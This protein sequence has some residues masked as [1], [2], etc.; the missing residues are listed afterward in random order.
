M[1]NIKNL[2]FSYKLGK[3]HISQTILSNFSLKV[4]RGEFVALL[5]KSGCGKTT[6]VNL[7]AGYLK[8]DSGIIKIGRKTKSWPDRDRIVIN[9]ENDLFEWMTAFQNIQIVAINKNPDSIREYLRLAGLES[10]SD[11]YPNELSGGMKKKLSLVR[12]LSAKPKFIILDEPFSSIDHISAEKLQVEFNL[13]VKKLSTTVILVTHS[14]SE[15]VFL[16]DR[17][18]VINGSPLEIVSNT[19]VD[20]P[21]P[22]GRNIIQTDKFKHICTKIKKALKSIE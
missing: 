4:K 20:L 16:S 14:I 10:F 1:L 12:A 9:Q 6:L 15:A 5:G 7:I 18:L 21:I 2:T 19:I 17:I 22:R 13:I 11:S 8:P 3:N